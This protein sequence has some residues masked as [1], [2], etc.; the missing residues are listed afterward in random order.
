MKKFVW[1]AVM[2]FAAAGLLLAACRKEPPPEV[3]E[4]GGT[5]VH[6][7]PDAPKTVDSASVTGFSC[8]F[9]TLSLL[10]EDTG[11]P[12]GVWEL[13]ADL[14]DETVSGSWQFRDYT[15][16]SADNAFE[17]DASFMDELQKIIAEYDLARYNGISEYVSGLPDMYG[18]E[19]DVQYASGETIYSSN[20]EECF[21]PVG[22]MKALTELFHVEIG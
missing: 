12:E 17:A 15:G 1:A 16:E 3:E 22:A 20:N 18:A 11:L 7:D 8:V 14:A 6:V 13:K 10:E 9:S 19:L 4:D 21:L 2:L 5:T